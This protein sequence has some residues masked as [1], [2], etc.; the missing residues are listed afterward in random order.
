MS[1]DMGSMQTFHREQHE[2]RLL[3]ARGFHSQSVSF[4]ERVNRHT[5]TSCGRALAVGRRVIVPDIE[6]SEFMAGSADLNVS[7]QAGIRAM[8]STPLISRSGPAGHDFNPLA[9]AASPYGTRASVVG[10]A[11]PTSRRPH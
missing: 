8:H 3:I 10:C 2:L 4:W 6:C 7:R 5:A 9:R 1:A 11:R